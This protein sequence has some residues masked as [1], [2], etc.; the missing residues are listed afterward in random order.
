MEL[1]QRSSDISEKGSMTTSSTNTEGL[2]SKTKKTT[3]KHH[4]IKKH[5]KGDKMFSGAAL[6]IPDI[7]HSQSSIVILPPI[8]VQSILR[9]RPV[10]KDKEKTDKKQGRLFLL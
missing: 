7:V 1:Y 5:T 2:G 10:E 8:R 3:Y 6:N 4:T 9:A